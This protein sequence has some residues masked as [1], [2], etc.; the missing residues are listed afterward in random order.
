MREGL[1]YAPRIQALIKQRDDIV[2]K[3]ERGTHL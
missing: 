2:T 3:L 1:A